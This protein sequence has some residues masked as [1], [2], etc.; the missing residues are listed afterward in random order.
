MQGG[1]VLSLSWEWTSVGGSTLY[2]PLY[3]QL[4][5]YG[6][7]VISYWMLLPALWMTNTLGTKTF[8]YPLTSSLFYENGTVFHVRNYLND[9]Y[10]LNEDA[11][12]AGPA[13]TMTPMYAL[14]FFFSFVPWLDALP[15]SFASMAVK[16][17]TPGRVLLVVR[18]RISTP[19]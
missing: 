19:R 18:V 2:L 5:F 16:S 8:G 10:S 4:C 14:Y 1:G 9:D 15:T 17:G 11:Y 3:A 6:G 13:A 7:T 12:N